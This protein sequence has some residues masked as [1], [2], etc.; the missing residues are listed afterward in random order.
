[1]NCPRAAF[2][3]QIIPLLAGGSHS[4]PALTPCVREE[5][6]HTHSCG[7]FENIP[8]VFPGIIFHPG[9]IFT[10]QTF[11]K[12][13]PPFG[14]ESR[15]STLCAGAFGEH[16]H[17]SAGVQS[18]RDFT[19]NDTDGSWGQREAEG[20]N[21]QE[22]MESFCQAERKKTQIRFKKRAEEFLHN[23]TET[24]VECFKMTHY[25]QPEYKTMVLQVHFITL[26]Y[27]LVNMTFVFFSVLLFCFL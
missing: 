3:W 8:P 21:R 17:A 13:N 10:I 25:S 27:M 26:T 18:D 11:W 23:I 15:N 2:S 7:W 4:I 20:D 22:R 6:D 5:I 9:D 14:P 12:G 16:I 19:W 1:M 24:F